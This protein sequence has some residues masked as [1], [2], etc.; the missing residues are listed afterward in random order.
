[1]ERIL[2]RREDKATIEDACNMTVEE[3][4]AKY[5]PIT[6]EEMLSKAYFEIRWKH[7]KTEPLKEEDIPKGKM[8]T[9]AVIKRS[10]PK[11]NQD[12][13][14]KPI[15]SNIPDP[16]KKPKQTRNTEKGDTRNARI[17]EL[18]NEGKAV[19]DII[20]IMEGEGYKVYAPQISNV[21]VAQKSL[22]QV[23]K[24]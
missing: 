13:V 14:H 8:I 5:K 18:L 20:A 9:F 4:V 1:M 23:G 3:F 6:K 7:K 10:K 15:I 21:R 17:L 16:D 22:I 24:A 12:Q 11:N 19:K 2:F